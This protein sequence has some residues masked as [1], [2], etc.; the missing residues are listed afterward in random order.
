MDEVICRIVDVGEG[1]VT[2]DG[3]QDASTRTE[4]G[5][6]RMEERE[7]RCVDDKVRRGQ[8]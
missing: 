2:L 8:Q 3:Q 6:G 7:R 4:E 1:M 5:G